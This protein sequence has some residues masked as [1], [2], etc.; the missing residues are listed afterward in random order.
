MQPCIVFGPDS[1]FKIKQTKLEAEMF[2]RSSHCFSQR[3]GLIVIQETSC[4]SKVTE[5]FLSSSPSLISSGVAL[6]QL[7]PR[8]RGTCIVRQDFPFLDSEPEASIEAQTLIPW[9]P[10]LGPACR[11]STSRL[12][13]ANDELM[14]QRWQGGFVN[15]IRN[16]HSGCLVIRLIKL[17]TDWMSGLLSASYVITLIKGETCSSPSETSILLAIWQ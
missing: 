6:V 12:A 10:C 2:L 1:H 11:C 4:V 13:A 15:P 9:L 3:L 14:T 8:P 17:Y 7:A 16:L 5:C